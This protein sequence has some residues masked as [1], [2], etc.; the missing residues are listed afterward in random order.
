VLEAKL[1]VIEATE[2]ARMV[3]IAQARE[4]LVRGVAAAQVLAD[5]HPHQHAMAEAPRPARGDGRQ[6]PQAAS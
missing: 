5:H 3:W 1:A 2:R 4:V 6:W